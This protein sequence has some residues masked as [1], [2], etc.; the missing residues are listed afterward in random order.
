MGQNMF[1][2]KNTHQLKNQEK[3]SH[4]GLNNS[5]QLNYI[6]TY[7]SER[8]ERILQGINADASLQPAAQYLGGDES[9]W[10]KIYRLDKPSKANW[11]E[12]QSYLGTIG[13]WMKIKGN[14]YEWQPRC[15]FDFT[16]ERELISESG[17]GFV[18]Q[19]KPET[20]NKQYQVII[21]SSDKLPIWD[22]L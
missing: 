1:S 4:Q 2:D 21:T 5:K 16:V 6:R 15:N 19:V 18:L 13:Y 9:C 10:K 8:V 20:E 11:K 17:G 7:A 22:L 3:N 14:K 12:P